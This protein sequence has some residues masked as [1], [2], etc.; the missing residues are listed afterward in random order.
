MIIVDREIGVAQLWPGP[1]LTR[2]E[3]A[4]VVHVIQQRVDVL[5]MGLL[6]V[7]SGT[8]EPVQNIGADGVVH[9]GGQT[10]DLAPAIELAAEL[11]MEKKPLSSA[12]EF[13]FH[14][15]P[16]VQ[17]EGGS[18]HDNAAARG[19]QTR[20]DAMSTNARHSRNIGRT[21]AV[22]TGVSPVP[23]SY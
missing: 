3:H 1:I 11:M 22:R 18:L 7:L 21:G 6:V 19:V 15:T 4:G 2:Q 13:S 16:V 23:S 5:G 20:T 17:A 12:I 10:V 9:W 14:E 8:V